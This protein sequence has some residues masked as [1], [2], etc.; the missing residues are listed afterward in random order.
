MLPVDVVAL[1]FGS[2]ILCTV[3]QMPAARIS[4]NNFQPQS[5][6]NKSRMA[7]KIYLPAG[8]AAGRGSCLVMTAGPAGLLRSRDCARSH[9]AKPCVFAG[10][11]T[12]EVRNARNTRL[13]Q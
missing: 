6:M 7:V 9:L 5:L 11:S 2:M 1:Y 13:R 10:R 8:F 3:S 4:E 12:T